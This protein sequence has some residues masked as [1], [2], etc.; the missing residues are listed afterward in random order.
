MPSE[1]I[2]MPLCSCCSRIVSPKDRGANKFPCPNCGAI[3][4]VRC[5][6]CRKLGNSY[7]CP[8][9]SFWGP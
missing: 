5:S 7:K 4:I 6:R 3:T 9:C 2:I 1:E 8:N